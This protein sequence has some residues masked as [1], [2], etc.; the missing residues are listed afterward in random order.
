MKC[1]KG[2]LSINGKCESYSN[3]IKDKFR[4]F[5]W[6]YLLILIGIILIGLIW[7]GGTHDWFNINITNIIPESPKTPYP[8]EITP[9]KE[10]ISYNVNLDINPNSIC[11]GGTITGIISTNIPNGV[12]SIFEDSSGT[13]RLLMNINLDINGDYTQTNR[14]YPLGVANVV[15]VCCDLSNNCKLSNV[16]R[17]QVVTCDT[18]GDGIPDEID[19]DDDNDGYSDIDEEIAGSDPK[20]DESYPGKACT[21]NDGG[22]KRDTPGYA[23]DGIYYYDK[24]VDGDTV[25]EYYCKDNKVVYSIEDCDANE[26]CLTTRSG[27]YCRTL[28]AEDSDGDGFTDEE[29]AAADTNPNDPTDYPGS[30]LDD[31]RCMDFCSTQGYDG[32]KYAPTYTMQQ[33]QDWGIYKCNLLFNAPLLNHQT[34]S[35]SGCCCYNCEF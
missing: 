27:G 31:E 14:I 19:D 11:S 5:R 8:I 1:E 28:E 4:W 25:Q 13:Y 33:C 21:E 34:Y 30:H 12:C 2:F 32:S 26:D 10:Y 24:C 9:A 35:T 16:E 3:Y 22:D 7:Y 29:E 18:D 23:N 6:W 20:D 15:A 17:L